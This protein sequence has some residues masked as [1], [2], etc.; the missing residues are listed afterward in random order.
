[1]RAFPDHPVLKGNFAPLGFEADAHDLVVE[2]EIPRD[3]RG[4]LYR[5]GPNPQYP[6]LAD[7]HHWFLGDG[8][9]HA[10]TIEDGCVSWRNRWVRTE[11]FERERAAGRRLY[12]SSF[13]G[14]AG[15][16][17]VAGSPRNVANTN[18]LMHGG[19][20]FALDEGNPPV[21]LDA[22]TLATRGRWTFGGRYAGPV[23]AHPKIDPKTGEM[24]FFGYMAAG[25]GSADIAFGVVNADGTL[26]R[27]ETFKAPFAAMV[28][29]FAVTQRHVVLPIWP[30]TIDV[31][32][33]MKGGPVIAWDP[34]AGSHIGIMPRDGTVADMRWFEG[35]SCYAYHYANAYDDGDRLMLDAVRYPR[36][37]L[38]PDAKGRS[39][40]EEPR[41]AVV[42]FT[43][44]LAGNSNGW[45]E[46][47]LDDAAAE[48]PR[49]DDRFAGSKNRYAY[50]AE[51]EGKYDGFGFFDA[52]L[53]ADLATGTRMRYRPGRGGLLM[54]PVF[55]PAR[56][57]A[58]EG[59][60]YILTLIYRPDTNTSDLLILDAMDISRGPL[61][62]VKLPTRIPFGFHGNWHTA[63][64]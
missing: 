53:S 26:V 42:R 28:H 1:M 63:R 48:F 19:R 61:A 62:T 45:R 7:K 49:I 52:L 43:F 14:A 23:T 34:A 5:N 6:P 27:A 13:D 15:D 56:D 55:A 59:E 40:P 30:A 64:T 21:A 47:T 12:S 31:A 35:N 46:E 9:V 37:P 36:V 17:S 44:D 20:L 16:P 2:G 33:I 57:D 24:L 11:Q 51:T 32:R 18:V 50:F 22:D 10:F 29:D 38:F 4:T 39:A 58:P 41:S 8:M 25:P 60:G 3:L 54:E